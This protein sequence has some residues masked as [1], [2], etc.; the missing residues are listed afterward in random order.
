MIKL[1]VSKIILFYH[2]IVKL[3][4]KPRCVFC[5]RKYSTE[6][7]PLHELRHKHAFRF[8]YYHRNCVDSVTSNPSEHPQKILKLA[9]HINKEV[10]DYPIE[11]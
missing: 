5:K 11:I 9:N 2:S 3:I 6:F 1:F 8:H 7:E 4:F 10:R